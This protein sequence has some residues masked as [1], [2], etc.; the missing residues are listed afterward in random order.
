VFKERLRGHYMARGGQ[1]LVQV[2]VDLLEAS[3]LRRHVEGVCRFECANAS[4][5]SH[6]TR[7]FIGQR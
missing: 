4:A 6:W 7:V 3:I 2:F 5:L 1:D